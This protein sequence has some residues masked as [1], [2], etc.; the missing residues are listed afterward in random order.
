MWFQKEKLQKYII[1]NWPF[2]SAQ[3]S[4]VRYNHIAEQQISRNFSTCRTDTL[5]TL[6]NRSPLPNSPLTDFQISSI[7][8]QPFFLMTSSTN[9]PLWPY[10]INSLIIIYL[11]QFYRIISIWLKSK[12]SIFFSGEAVSFTEDRQE[13]DISVGVWNQH[14]SCVHLWEGRALAGARQRPLWLSTPL[15]WF[16]TRPLQKVKIKREGSHAQ[17]GWETLDDSKLKKILHWEMAE[18]CGHTTV[19]GGVSQNCSDSRRLARGL[20]RSSPT[21]VRACWWA[22][23]VSSSLQC[24]EG[25]H[26]LLGRL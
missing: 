19:T 9:T 3:F 2:L 4:N 26:F 12:T 14:T 11:L 23:F 22:G 18:S 7:S 16:L 6:N 5:Y 24:E 25:S 20:Q 10:T 21:T 8:F 17:I 1:W 13:A 15:C